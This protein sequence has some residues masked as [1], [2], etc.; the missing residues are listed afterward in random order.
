M[1]VLQPIE[2]FENEV[3]QMTSGEPVAYMEQNIKGQTGNTQL[4][5]SCQEQTE[6]T[7]CCWVPLVTQ[8]NTWKQLQD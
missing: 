8:N 6:L 5:C 4:V 2:T 3:I 1:T 7:S